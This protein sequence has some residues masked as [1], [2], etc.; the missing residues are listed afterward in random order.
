MGRRSSIDDATAERLL[1]AYERLGSKPKAAAEVGVSWGAASRFFA[2]LPAAAAPVITTT[3]AVAVTA[4]VS[5]WET[6]AALDA[7][8]AR[9]QRLVEVAQ[10]A[11]TT[12]EIR[13]YV[14]VLAEIREHVTTG[15][16]LMQTLIDVNEVRAFQEAVL[17]A[18]GEADPATRERIVNRLKERR[19][20]GLA[21]REP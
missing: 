19:A 10:G 21:L 3:P 6:R 17:E 11:T 12:Q 4:G 13:T 20:L 7:N 14:A 5:L 8:Y 16:K 1:A 2:A 15:V 18:I 9:L